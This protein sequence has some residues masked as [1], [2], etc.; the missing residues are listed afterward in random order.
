M[1]HR[2]RMLSAIRGEPI[3][4]IPWAPR[5]D[6]W[7]AANRRAGTLPPHLPQTS[8]RD[9][10]DALA[11]GYHAVI[12]PLKELRTDADDIDRALGLYNIH[13][14]PAHTELA[15]VERRVRRDGDRTHVEYDTPAGTVRTTVLYDEAMRRAGV[16]ITHIE[17]HAFASPAD[18]APLTHIFRSLRVAPEPGYAAFADCVGDRGLPVACVSLAASPMQHI[19]RDLMPLDRFFFELADHPGE[20]AELADAISG[21]Y[22]RLFDVAVASGA[23]VCLLGANYDAGV[24]PPPFFARHIEPWLRRLADRLHAAGRFLLTHTDG[25]NRGLLPH[26]VAAG[27]DVAD[28]VCPA[29][30]TSLSMREHREVLSPA[31][32][33]IMGGV[34]SVAL[35]ADAMSDAQ[36]EAYMDDF[37]EQIGDGSR[38]ILGV[39][40]TTPPA[41]VFDR[42]RRVAER[43]EA[44][45][46]VPAAR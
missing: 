18:Y 31:G 37:F 41:A 44:F 22:E 36:F 39:S 26:Y 10:T 7:F 9:F 35:L 40:D 1:T 29:P 28:S 32:I 5:L 13:T 34:P 38:L 43:V 45:G 23:E 3:D 2:Q 24:T 42:L 6:L 17:R 8:L 14:L 4:R 12:P 19:Q 20:L 11:W 21:Y 30:M 27:V 46:P 33:T 25:E 16:S 15:D